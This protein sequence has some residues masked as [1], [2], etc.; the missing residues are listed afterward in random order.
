MAN[1]KVSQLTTKP[2]IL[3]GD[4]IPLADPTTGQLYKATLS[5]LG[6]VIG[7]AVASV[8]GLVGTVVLDTD[9][10]QE[11][12]SPTNK[13]Y[14]DTR[15][16][17]ALSAASPLTYN[18]GTGAFGIQAAN[19]SQ[20]GYLSSTDW[21]A[22]SNTVTG[23][24]LKLNI[25]DAVSTYQR[26]DKMVSN[27]LASDTEYP[28]SNA[29]LA[30][31]ALKADTT[32]PVFDGYMTIGGAYPKI[33]LTDSDNNPDY[34]IGNDDGYFRIYDQT[35][36]TSRFYITSSG[37]SIFPG[38]VTVGS[39]AKDG[40]TSAQFLK[41]DGSVDSS[42]YATTS[43]LSSYLLSTTAA[44]TYQRKDKMVSNLL[45]SDTEYP[46]SN[47]V[48]AK[49]A[50]KADAADPVFTGNLTISGAA[51]K[52]YFVDTDQNPDYTLFADAG[53]FYIYDQTAGT[54]RFYIT[55]SGVATVP[56]SMVVGSIAKSGGLST[57][58]LMADGSVSTG[59]GG[60]MTYPG[61]GI[62]LSTGSAWGT[63][64]TNNSSNWN[65]AYGWGNHAGLYLP[66]GGG[67]L[68]GG[69]TG[70]TAT[71]SGAV[72]LQAGAN[73]IRSGN[74]LRFNR[75]D[76]AI[77]T[78]LYDAGSGAANGFILNNTN[79]EG[80][81]FKNGATSIMR[82]PSNGNVGIGTTTPTGKL[83]VVLPAFTNEDTD[84]QQAI[85]GSGTSGYGVRIGYNESNNIGYIYSLKPSVAWS[86]LKFA[87][88]NIIFGGGGSAERMRITSDGSLCFGTTSI[89]DKFTLN[90]GIRSTGSSAGYFFGNRSNSAEFYGWYSTSNIAYLFNGTANII[91][92]TNAGNLTATG[93]FE[94]SDKTIKTLIED[95]YQAKGIESIT[96]KL[97]LK[98]GVEELGYFAQ[99]VQPIL[100]SAVSKGENGLLN[101]S[102]R[103][104]HTAKI[105]RLEKEIEELKAKLN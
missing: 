66:I 76:N 53:Y 6:A 102:Y 4:I 48:L 97:Y 10:I 73:V 3:T 68:T 30:K 104:V 105:A 22:F 7:S 21:T 71:F 11:L 14:T 27:L 39:I 63:S 50:L 92:I 100:P 26:I 36:T 37:A 79:G 45:A 61:A 65:T 29:V 80:F 88:S 99:D 25:T 69:L 86:D 103:E 93:F 38:G 43:S 81:H 55:P 8:N 32:N 67:T 16:R 42:T 49:L 13:W 59:G 89:L 90:G 83:H 98:N 20:N 64:I 12:A 75:A 18:S 15:A 77:Y 78:Q 91:S 17:A 82:M 54:S 85:F 56:G 52:L 40:G 94:S 101:L 5:S 57:E 24:A 74:D 31:L 84:S 23:L 41:A 58:Y 47:A 34:F 28:N 95:N 62:A 2:S 70:T 46:N 60:S 87:G 33:Y 1:K 96:A 35:N 19:G 51:P 44:D 9:D 72:T